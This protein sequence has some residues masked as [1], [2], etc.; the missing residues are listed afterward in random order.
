MYEE[1][2]SPATMDIHVVNFLA[3][4]VGMSCEE[5]GAYLMLQMALWRGD[6]YLPDDDVVL[7]R[8]TNSSSRQW[9]KIKP[10]VLRR[11][12]VTEDGRIFCRHLLEERILNSRR[13]GILKR[14][15][16]SGKA[17]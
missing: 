7:R 15:P 9:S 13:I 4:T 14:T 5:V 16:R 11:F 10:A 12:S 3:N 2:A 1:S 8:I 6:G 17:K